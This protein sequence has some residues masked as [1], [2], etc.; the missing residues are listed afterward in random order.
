[1]QR[2]HLFQL[3]M[4]AGAAFGVVQAQAQAPLASAA[5]ES[6]T[7]PKDSVEL[8]RAAQSDQASF[9]RLR[10]SRL[11]ETWGRGSS[12]CDERIGRFCLT[13][14]TGRDDW[15][16]PPEH[17]EIIQTRNR[18]IAGLGMVADLMPGDGWVAGQRVRY[19][20]EARR[21]DESLVAARA[22][23]GERWWCAALEGFAHHYA[24]QA[25]SADSAFSSA[26]AAM[27]ESE[28]E[29]WS[30]LS[31]VLDERTIRTYRRMEPE[32]RAPF[33]DRFWR[34][35][36]P[37][38]T[39]PGNEL[40]SEH[41]ARHVW[42]RFQLEARTTDAISWGYDL[43]EILVRYGWPTGWERTR[44]W[45][46]AAQ[47]GPPPLVS[48]YSSAPQYLLPPS[49]ALL[50]GNGTDGLWDVEAP[51]AR[52]GY[53]VPLADSIAQWF[54]PLDHQ[55]A[56]FRRGTEAVIVAGYALPA[57]SVP[58]DA[59]VTAGL[60]T[61]PTTDSLAEPDVMVDRE[62][63]RSGSLMT[64]VE[65]RPVLM[66]LEIVVPEQR[67]LARARYG[68]DLAPV[69]PGLLSLSD[70]LLL[71]DAEMLPDS[72]P[73][74]LATVR[75]STE[76]VPGEQVGLY[77]EIYGLDVAEAPSVAMSLRLLQA[78]TG[79]LRRLAE[80]AGLLRE[81]A[82]I[83]LRWEEP[84]VEGP[85]MPRSLDVQIPDV[86]PGTYSLELTLETPGR[87]PLSVTREIE[88]VER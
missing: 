79:W 76:V 16:A 41:L 85:Y 35:S 42:D 65:A 38:L 34:L 80:R 1:M 11:P 68:L 32:E 29:R 51:K 71:N 62:S 56:I 23:R 33:E 72:L 45:R 5:V 47:A 83:R 12:Q 81:V 8:V 44:E 48:H 69:P 21:F 22:C 57:D 40:R 28:R 20:V 49:E 3:L 17:E 27:E 54:S 60:A 36:D 63:S 55:V 9:E 50:E 58:E 13:H 39:R 43:R 24:A 59:A 19:L 75:G 84:T 6:R 66:S 10:R 74:A 7:T 88:V 61:L 52:T 67:R 64:L 37:L 25:E 14:G 78:Q 15:V 77:W 4:V 86:S 73:D 70:I 2:P 30:D 46:M 53:N 18:L 87:E 26:L 31:M 82:P